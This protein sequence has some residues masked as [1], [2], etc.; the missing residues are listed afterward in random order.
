M[1]A[2]PSAEVNSVISSPQPDWALVTAASMDEL[3][4]VV[5]RRG[6]R[7]QTGVADEAAEDGV[8]DARHGSQHRGRSHHDI[9]QAHLGR[10]ARLGGHGVLPGVV[11][12]LL[13]GKALAGHKN[14]RVAKRSWASAMAEAQSYLCRLPE[15]GYLAAAASLAPSDLANLRRK[16]STRP[17][18]STR[19]C[20]PVK[21]GWQ[22]EQIST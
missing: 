22:T 20:L 9:A 12:V 21:N 17:A 16:R 5:S 2:R 18:V 1:R 8:R 14:L 11:P 10:H 6:S 15:R 4:G 13:H 7:E 3:A 19:R